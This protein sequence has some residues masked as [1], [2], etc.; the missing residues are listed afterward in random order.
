MII[1]LKSYIAIQ[2]GHQFWPGNI[3]GYQNHLPPSI[4]HTIVLML[5][6][7]CSSLSYARKH[8]HLKWTVAHTLGSPNLTTHC[9]GLANLLHPFILHRIALNLLC[10]CLISSVCSIL[11]ARKHIALMWTA[12][13]IHQSHQIWQGSVTGYFAQNDFKFTLLLYFIL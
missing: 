2:Q 1:T 8:F 9:Y 3:R 13:N 10:C 11:Y 6:K 12:A 4:S 5:P 7:C